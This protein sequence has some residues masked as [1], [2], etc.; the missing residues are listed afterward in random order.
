MRIGVITHHWVANFGANLQALSTYR[1]LSELGH[2]V[3]LLNY[4]APDLEQS[5]GRD[6]QAD[7]LKL[8]ED[9]C[10]THLRQSPLCRSEKDLTEFCQD[11][12]LQAILVGSD[13]VF[14]LRRTAVRE[15]TQFPNPFWLLW[16][17]SDLHPRP[18]TASLAASSMATR[19]LLYPA[20][21]RRG[22]GRAIRN[23]D[24]VSVRDQ[25]TRWNLAVLTTFRSRPVLCPDPVFLLNDVFQVPTLDVEEPRA[26]DKKYVILSLF[27]DLMSDVWVQQFVEIA[28]DHEFQVF[29]L[30]FP[31]GI[32][33]L[34]VDRTL[35]LPMSPLRWYAWL[36][37]A[38][39][40]VGPRFHP[41]VCSIS[42]GV[43]FLSLDTYQWR[44]LPITSKTYD[45]CKQANLRRFWFNA[46]GR[47]RL[48]PQQAFTLLQDKRQ[49]EAR[50]YVRGARRDFSR[51]VASLL[52]RR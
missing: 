6:V 45:L 3:W 47:R 29:T 23:L 43:P 25:W 10:N 14:R 26:H 15:D 49:A 11:T 52:L 7:Q 33:P 35:P 50:R 16:A 46:S 20:S 51:I 48:D 32:A 5:L 2:D 18:V 42:N 12:N 13:A 9:F 40:Y 36:K 28:H 17:N 24:H 8:H 41:V 27:E 38:A 34:P 44:S 1:F 19:F 31:E 37:H 4:R 39:A 22:I 30:P 21:V